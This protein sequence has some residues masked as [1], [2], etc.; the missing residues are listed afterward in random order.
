MWKIKDPNLDQ[1]SH[2]NIV[3]NYIYRRFSIH[4]HVNI[5]LGIPNKQGIDNWEV[6]LQFIGCFFK[7]LM[8]ITFNKKLFTLFHM[9]GRCVLVHS[10]SRI[11][12]YPKNISHYI[13]FGGWL[14][15]KVSLRTTFYSPFYFVLKNLV[16]HKVLMFKS[17]AEL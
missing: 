6:W 8:M 12:P 2:F 13:F 3:H 10:L 14:Q 4:T 5:G 1:C 16:G 7:N 11:V 9:E 17:L 15:V